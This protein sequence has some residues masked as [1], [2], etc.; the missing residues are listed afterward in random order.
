[1]KYWKY[2]H[3]SEVTKSIAEGKP[4]KE[5]FIWSETQ[6]DADYSDV[7]TTEAVLEMIKSKYKL[8]QDDGIAYFE[9]IRAD[10]VLLYQSGQ[11]TDV[12]IFLIESKLEGTIN[13]IV[14]GDWMTAKAALSSVT[15]EAPLDQSLH[16]EIFA[17]IT[18]YI[19]DNY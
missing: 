19:A 10:I 9:K 3:F 2:N 8:Y 16:D 5:P 4:L 12:E 1:M 13:K 7:T 11:K 18:Q 17:F 14:R 6:P 15:V